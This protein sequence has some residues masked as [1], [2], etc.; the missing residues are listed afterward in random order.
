MGWIAALATIRQPIRTRRVGL[1]MHRTDGTWLDVLLE[2]R[3]EAIRT[4]MG[5]MGLLRIRNDDLDL[6]H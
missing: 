5:R 1:C 6:W 4:H 3:M 2:M